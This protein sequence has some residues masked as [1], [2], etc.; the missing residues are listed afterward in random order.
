M[1]YADLIQPAE[2]LET[3]KQIRESASHDAARR[4][5]ETFVI[6]DRMAGQLV[7]VIFR[8]L[9]YDQPGD[10]K[11]ILTSDSCAR[12]PPSEPRSPSIFG[13]LHEGMAERPDRFVALFAVHPDYLRNGRCIEPLSGT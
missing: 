13:P 8:N 10:Q 7:D 9:R 6:S 3:V 12:T 11:G 2:P 5:V 4:D 1:K